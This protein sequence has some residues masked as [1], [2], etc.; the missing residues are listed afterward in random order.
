MLKNAHFWILITTTISFLQGQE[1]EVFKIR[2]EDCD[3]KCKTGLLNE[4]DILALNTRVI[5]TT[6]LLNNSAVIFE[7]RPKS[8]PSFNYLFS[9]DI[10]SDCTESKNPGSNYHC[11]KISKNMF[12]ITFTFN[13]LTAL[14]EATVRGEIK[15]YNLTTIAHSEQTLPIICEPADVAGVLKINGENVTDLNNCTVSLKEDDLNLEFKCIGLAKPCVIEITS[16]DWTEK[17]VGDNKM[18]IKR[19]LNQAA[20]IKISFALCRFDKNVFNVTCKVIEVSPKHHTEKII[21]VLIT[22][23]PTVIVILFSLYSLLKIISNHLKEVQ[24]LEQ[25]PDEVVAFKPKDKET[26][27]YRPNV[28]FVVSD[29]GSNNNDKTE[30]LIDACLHGPLEDVKMLIQSDTDI[31]KKDKDGLTPL[32]HALEA[33]N[34]D[35]IELLIQHGAD[36]EERTLKGMTYLMLAADKGLTDIAE[37]LIDN[38][39]NINATNKTG[40]T[41]L[42]IASLHGHADIVA[43][44]MQKG[45]DAGYRNKDGMNALMCASKNGH[46]YIVKLIIEDWA[47][48]KLTTSLINERTEIGQNAIMFASLNGHTETVELLLQHNA[49][50]RLKD[51]KGFTCLMFASLNGH[52]EIVNKIMKHKPEVNE[53][54]NEGFTPLM[55]ASQEGHIETIKV[56]IEKGVDVNAQNTSGRTAL[57]IASSKGH[58]EIAHYL[59]KLRASVNKKDSKQMTALMY[60]LKNKNVDISTVLLKW[61]AKVKQG[62]KNGLT[63]LMFASMHGLNEAVKYII[64]KGARVDDKTSLGLNALMYACEKGHTETAEMLVNNGANVNAKNIAGVNAL[65]LASRQGHADICRL[66]IQ[67]KAAVSERDKQ[68]KTALM[69]ARENGHFEIVDLLTHVEALANEANN[70]RK[71]LKKNKQTKKIALG[72]HG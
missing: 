22:G 64:K 62:D 49:D 17:K 56:L 50:V 36:C 28:S 9:V 24:D 71:D 7:I 30:A 20:E 33:K 65:M 34:T 18:V 46:T 31:N 61:G 45:S 32:M 2:Q 16:S 59:C 69:Y 44:L 26:T 3:T 52:T 48:T 54:N 11:I 55:L 42:M 41:A 66:L 6:D 4:I 72:I 8:S 39:A 12:N 19:S 29:G 5:L 37:M 15:H 1:I 63:C 10:K 25:N 40:S 58:T 14:S 43:M 47:K 21:I 70:C 53:K 51:W 68:N 57:M 60:A 67:Y 13:A 27:N 35:I 23:I 38:N